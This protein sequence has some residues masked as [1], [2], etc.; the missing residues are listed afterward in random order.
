MSIRRSYMEM[1]QLQNRRF[2]LGYSQ[3]KL[4]V[5]A[6]V[7][8]AMIVAI[9]KYGYMPG[10]WVRSKL[11]KVLGVSEAILWPKTKEVIKDGESETHND[12]R[13]IC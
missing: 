1:N 13:G 4:S 5:I 3:L 7:S 11:V 12:N 10:P 8:P 6:G 9:E 2:A